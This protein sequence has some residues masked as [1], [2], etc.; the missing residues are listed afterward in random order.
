VLTGVSLEHSAAWQRRRFRGDL[1]LWNGHVDDEGRS[2]GLP[3]DAEP[4]Q[5]PRTIAIETIHRFKGLE[6]D[7]AVLVE[8]RPDDERLGCLLYIGAT[9]AKHHLVVIAPPELAARLA[10]GTG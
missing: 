8:L 6:R 5:P 10:G 2:L 7:V 3:F 4:A 1:V 9:R